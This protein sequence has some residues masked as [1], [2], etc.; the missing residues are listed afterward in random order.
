MDQ[1]RTAEAIAIYERVQEPDSYLEAAHHELMRGFAR[2][3]ETARARQHFQ[4]LCQ[5]LRDELGTQPSPETVQLDT[6][7]GAGLAI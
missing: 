3:A 7:I 4:R 2:Q 1:G 5:V 6:Q